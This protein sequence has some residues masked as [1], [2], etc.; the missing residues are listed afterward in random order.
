MDLSPAPANV[1]VRRP[2]AFIDA[3]AVEAWDAWFRWREHG[4]LRDVTIEQTW[5]RV[6]TAL[7]TP[8]HANELRDCARRFADALSSWRLL[9]DERLLA[10]ADAGAGAQADGLAATLN[11]AAFVRAPFTASASFDRAGFE[12]C[13]ELAVRG[14]DNAMLRAGVSNRDRTDIR[15][16]VIGLGDALALLGVAYGSSEGRAFAADAARTLAHACVHASARLARE[17]GGTPTKRDLRFLRHTEIAPRPR[18][19]LFANHVADAL[20]PIAPENE[21]VIDAPLGGDRHVRSSGYAMALKRRIEGADASLALA[22]VSMAD[23]ES[24]RAA[25]APFIDRPIVGTL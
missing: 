14:L 3:A 6:A 2:A 9:P 23:R 20:D 17:R 25:C 21:V 4:V 18:L 13:A 12:D 5:S 11:L 19:A 22:P 16:G 10:R 8:E 7:A 24:M 1:R 15:V